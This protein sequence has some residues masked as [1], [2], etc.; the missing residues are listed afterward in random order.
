M[1]DKQSGS[2]M[3]VESYLQNDK[4]GGLETEVGILNT[5]Y[6]EERKSSQQILNG[7]EMLTILKS[8]Q[9]TYEK[10]ASKESTDG[11]FNTMGVRLLTSK[12]MKQS[13]KKEKKKKKKGIKSMEELRKER[14]QRE[15]AERKREQVVLMASGQSTNSMEGNCNGQ[16]YFSGYGYGRKRK[17]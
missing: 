17:Q 9:E 6:Q 14:I 10:V 13:V 15:E 11:I 7:N 3:V 16:G 12:E 1:T 8:Q 5:P 4:K 2:Y